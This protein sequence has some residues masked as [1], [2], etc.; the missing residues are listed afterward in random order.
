M[1]DYSREMDISLSGYLTKCEIPIRIECAQFD[2]ALKLIKALNDNP[3]Y[4]P[5]ATT[6]CYEA[7]TYM[8]TGALD[9]ARAALDSARGKVRSNNDS[10][11]LYD[12]LRHYA[13]CMGD[14]DLYASSIDSIFSIQVKIENG[15]QFHPAITA[16][17]EYNHHKAE[18]D[19][20]K[21]DRTAF[22]VIFLAGICAIIVTAVIIMQRRRASEAERELISRASQ[23]NDLAQLLLAA[24]DSSITTYREQWRTLNSLIRDYYDMKGDPKFRAKLLKNLSEEIS[25]MSSENSLAEIEDNLNRLLDNVVL[26]IRT[27]LNFLDEDDLRLL[28]YTLAGWSPKA[29]SLALGISK[30]NCATRKSRILDQISKSE[31]PDREWLLSLFENR[32]KNRT[33][34]RVE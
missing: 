33:E 17:E 18:S 9:K 12:G 10:I 3:Y 8:E 11:H 30:G 4:V 6:L 13:Q 7:Y 32:K 2:K 27:Q 34:S 29:I 25:N 15:D 21:A 26:R 14:M 5:S 22:T 28:I 1:L 31:V 20:D 23:I 24:R 19:K 16:M